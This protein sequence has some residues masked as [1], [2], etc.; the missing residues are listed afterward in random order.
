MEITSGKEIEVASRSM[1]SNMDEVQVLI[2]I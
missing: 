2:Y 1:T